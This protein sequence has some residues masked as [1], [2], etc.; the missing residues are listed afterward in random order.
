MS[1]VTMCQVVWV[2]G[3]GSGGGEAWW[4]PAKGIRASQCICFSFIMKSCDY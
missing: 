4:L 1:V 2:G 3:R